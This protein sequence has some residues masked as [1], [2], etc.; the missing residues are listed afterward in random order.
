[1]WRWF[2]AGLSVVAMGCSAPALDAR[3]GELVTALVRADE[4]VI[5]ARPELAAGKFQRMASAPFDFYRGTLPVFRLDWELGRTSRSGFAT[6]TLPVLGLADPQP[7]NF[8]I[9]VASD[10]TAGFEPNDFDSA[11]RVPYLFDL[12]RLLGGLALGVRLQSPGTSPAAIARDAARAYAESMQ[13]FA[14]GAQPERIESPGGSLILDDLFRRSA[15]D[16]ASRAELTQLTVV[17][18]ETRRFRRGVIDPAE[19]TETLEDAPSFVVDAVPDALARLGEDPAWTVLDV[20]RQFGSGVASWPRVRF[21]VLVRGPTDAVDDDVILELKELAESAVAGW[22][23]PALPADDTPARVES[24]L[25]RS[26]ARPDADPRWFTTEWL[27]FPFQVRTESEAHKNL[28]VSRWVGARATPVELSKLAVVLGQLL[29]RIHGRSGAAT[30]AS[31][32]AQVGRDIDVFADEQANFAEVHSQAS[33]DDYARF[34]AA[35][36]QL[37]PTLG[38]RVDPRELPSPTLQAFYGDPP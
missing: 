9:L 22:Y 3:T 29:A 14:A 16:L 32:A 27:G 24:A 36:E 33:L 20:V 1:M 17:E 5:R 19:P 35:L 13:A 10:R 7:E 34:Q 31:V 38:L 6:N 4:L 28:R 11:D 30:V 21:L 12:R 25:R 2:A 18:G 26:W 8:G 15:R 37:G 23:R